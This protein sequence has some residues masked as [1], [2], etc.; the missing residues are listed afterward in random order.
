MRRGWLLLL[1]IALATRTV[2]DQPPRR[3][4]IL[5]I[6]RVHIIVKNFEK[7]VPFYRAMTIDDCI[8]G[9][10]RVETQMQKEGRNPGYT[11]TDRCG[12]DRKPVPYKCAA[13]GYPVTGWR[14]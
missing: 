14:L 2:A 1:L 11:M 5:E 13:S 12:F 3:P 7:A 8:D 4:H 9:V 10:S 6:V